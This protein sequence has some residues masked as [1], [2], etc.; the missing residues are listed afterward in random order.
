MEKV[1]YKI[2]WR[3]KL[4]RKEID[5]QVIKKKC[6]FC[7]FECE[8]TTNEV[9]KKMDWHDKTNHSAVYISNLLHGLA[10]KILTEFLRANHKGTETI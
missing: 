7:N 6:K 9:K 2:I 1:I 4:N 10:D 3:I 8:G 5:K